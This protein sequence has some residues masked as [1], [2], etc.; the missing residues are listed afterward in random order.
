[1]S[2]LLLCFRNILLIF[3][4]VRY[5]LQLLGFEDLSW[6]TIW[7]ILFRDD[8]VFLEYYSWAHGR[9]SHH[10]FGRF[11]IRNV[12]QIPPRQGL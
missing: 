6:S 3:Y 2:S 7:F 4:Q 9:N 1:M 5:V 11:V 12:S 8:V 10:E